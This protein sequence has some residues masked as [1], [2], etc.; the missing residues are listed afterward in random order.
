MTR[1]NIDY[2]FNLKCNYAR[3]T[4][5]NNLLVVERGTNTLYNISNCGL[6]SVVDRHKGFEESVYG[7]KKQINLISLLIILEFDQFRSFRYAKEDTYP[8]WRDSVNSV[9]MLDP[10][11]SEPVSKSIRVFENIPEDHNAIFCVYNFKFNQ[12]I[13]YSIGDENSMVHLCTL[14]DTFQIDKIKINIQN[15]IVLSS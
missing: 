7:K 15:K 4:N 13:G 1:V 8:I 10:A 6:G 3:I 2:E 5:E 12:L 11:S 9:V 14:N